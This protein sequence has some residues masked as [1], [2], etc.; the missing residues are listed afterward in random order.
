MVNLVGRLARVALGVGALVGTVSCGSSPSSPTPPGPSPGPPAGPV[1]LV[2]AGDIADCTVNGSAQTASLLDGIEGTVMALG[3][4]AYPSGRTDDFQNC[5]APRWGRHKSRIRPIPGNHEYET[6]G[7]AGYYAYFG[8]A[9]SAPDGYYSF[10]HGA[11]LVVALNTNIPMA[12]GSPQYE[13]LRRELAANAT[14]CV[15]ALMHH[16]LFTSGDH[17]QHTEVRPL[18]ELLYQ[19]G[20]ELVATGDDHGYERFAPQDPGGRADL[21]RGV[22]QFVVGTGGAPLT[23]FV[24][25]RPN[26]EVQLSSWGVLR[27]TL[28]DGSYS[29]EFVPVAGS[30]ARDSGSEACH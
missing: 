6:P 15:A 22:R 12:A 14:T 3:D 26:S 2:G 13:W 4:L 19:A 24:G 17:M 5:F 21:Q 28:A 18:W 11:W 8:S 1:T 10:R 7:A 23:R 29:W 9:A 27:L 30:T 16:P 20:A 25:V